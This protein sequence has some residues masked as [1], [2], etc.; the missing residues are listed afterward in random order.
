MVSV[1]SRVNSGEAGDIGVVYVLFIN[2]ETQEIW[3]GATAA[4]SDLWYVDQGYAVTTNLLL[5]PDGT[6]TDSLPV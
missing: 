6:E 5:A 4:A 3:Q 1:E 2:Y